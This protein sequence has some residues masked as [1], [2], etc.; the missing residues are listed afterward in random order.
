MPGAYLRHMTAIPLYLP[1]Y[2][3]LPEE[4]KVKK[5]A[6]LK[7]SLF[8]RKPL[9]KVEA[10]NQLDDAMI[11]LIEFLEPKSVVADRHDYFEDHK[12]IQRV[13]LEAE[14]KRAKAIMEFQKRPFIY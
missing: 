8:K 6:L 9:R 1:V 14:Q 4:S 5:M 2:S 3:I 12:E 11:S 7:K 10:Y 13:L